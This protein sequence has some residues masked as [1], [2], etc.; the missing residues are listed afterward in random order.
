MLNAKRRAPAALGHTVKTPTFPGK[1][2]GFRRA[3]G[4]A[5][6]EEGVQKMSIDL[7]SS[8]F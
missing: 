5:Q 7:I 6:K 2:P 1:R 4:C 8:S 3:A